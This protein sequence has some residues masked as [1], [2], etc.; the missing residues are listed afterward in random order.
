MSGF[1]PSRPAEFL[2]SVAVALLLG[3]PPLGAQ[4][5]PIQADPQG[6]VER[7]SRTRDRMILNGRWR[8]QP[9]TREA[10]K[11]P[12]AD[13]GLLSVPGT[14]QRTGWMHGMTGLP[15]PEKR[16]SGAAWQDLGPNLGR[17]WYERE[18]TI[19][20]EW[21]GRRIR[22]DFRRVSTDATVWIDRT[23]CGR[24]EWPY[25]VVDITKAARPGQKALLRVLVVATPDPGESVVWMGTAPGQNFSVKS[26]LSRS[27]LIGDV[28]LES[29]PQ[30]AV[31]SDV[32][33]Q[34]SVARKELAIDVELEGFR[35]AAGL[36]FE[37]RLLDESGT[38]EQRFTA[39]A[40]PAGTGPTRTARL[41]FP[42][43]NPRLWDLGRPNLYTLELAARGPGIDDTYALRFGFREFRVEGRKFLLNGREI[44]L[45]PTLQEEPGTP[46]EID[47]VIDGMRAAGFNISQMWPTDHDKRG[48]AF[49]HRELWAER[50]DAKGWLTMGSLLSMAPY[51][52]DTRYRFIWNAERRE[53]YRRRMEADL[54]RYRNHPSIVMWGTTGNFFN[55]SADQDPRYLG[56]RG[57]VPSDATDPKV[58]AGREALDLIRKADPTR[59]VFT[60]AGNRMGDVF[61]IN[62]YLN[63]IP[64]QEREE[65]PSEWARDGEMPVL[66]IEFGNPLFCDFLRGR[67]A[68]QNN[69]LSEPLLTEHAA[70]FLGPEAY[71]IETPEYRA[72]IRSRY[73]GAEKWQNW[74]S[75]AILMGAPAMDKVSALLARNTWRAWRTWGWSGGMIPWDMH[76]HHFRSTPPAPQPAPPFQP[77]QRGPSPS[78]LQTRLLHYLKPEGGWQLNEAGRA[79]LAA[80]GP[81]LAWIAGPEPHFT[82]KDHNYRPGTRFE[83]QAIL[84]NDE[85]DPQTFTLSWALT[86]GDAVL[87]E[88][89]EQGEL[90]SAE[91]RRIP[92][93]ADLPTRIAAAK[94]DALLTLDA[95]IGGDRHHDR[96]VF[97]IHA[98]EPGRAKTQRLRT[99]DPLGKTKPLLAHLNLRPVDW[100]GQPHP[101]LLIVG[102]EA[103]SS[104]TPLPG[105]PSP[106]RPLRALEDYVLAGGRVLVMTQS[107]AW[108]RDSVGF[109]TLT[110]PARAVFPVDP[111]HPLVAGL[112]AD[113]LRDWSGNAT[114]LEP[115]PKYD[116]ASYPLH[117]W[118]WG[119][120]GVVASVPIEKPHRSG[121]RPL[122]EC[123]FDLAYSPL[124]ELD[125]GKGRITLCTLDLEDCHAAD[126]VA[127]QLARR[128]I[129]HAASAPLQPRA[130]RV[131]LL[132][133]AGDPTLTPIPGVRGERAAKLAP[134]GGLAIIGPDAALPA[135]DLEAYLAAGGR[136]FFLAA[137]SP[138]G[139]PI[140]ALRET[141]DYAGSTEPPDWPETAGIGISDLHV[142]SSHPAWLLEPGDGLD[143]AAGGL[144]GR[145]ARGRGTLFFCQ[146]DPGALPADAQPWLRF[147]RWRQTRLVTQLLANHGASFDADARFFQPRPER[148]DLTGIWEYL[149]TR[150]L[151]ASPDPATRTADPGISEAA[152]ALIAAN[153]T[154]DA[155]P[156]RVSGRDQLPEFDKADGEAVLW[157]TFDLP[158]DAAQA[159]L[160]L[161]LGALDDFDQVFLN[162][163]LVGETGAATPT[164]W[165]VRRSYRIPPG[166]A[167]AGS[168]RIAIR[169]FD[170]Y[171]GGGFLPADRPEHLRILRESRGLP[172]F[173]HPDYRADRETGDDPERYYR[174]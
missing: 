53:T 19:P 32:F 148:I 129:V 65:M 146:A 64:S 5:A 85:R 150:P 24:V 49:Q 37:A 167:V 75:N 31:I 13:W 92:I 4:P 18:I 104:G 151:P 163:K 17:A 39:Q 166:I 1:P 63:L 127:D 79:L 107:P 126:P 140:S 45:R 136:A 168:N 8:F 6:P 157:T 170:A 34:P 155:K 174:W 128:L 29:L 50:A 112:D 16:G 172:G 61:T 42:W 165:S 80:N 72:A 124:L 3:T 9:A 161:E 46:A 105:T 120:R 141:K 143:I 90:A 47:G 62:H 122:L 134:D 131:Q 159:A 171:G 89:T 96:F 77:G 101:D 56:R 97:R 86:A 55:Q 102:R 20:A 160:T 108:L 33:V 109:R 133:N 27:G 51:I 113:D 68:F 106:E 115:R 52:V 25:G 152:R 114:L 99:W 14:W 82:A 54:R 130:E 119:N 144:L 83:K 48:N 7:V 2:R 142:R 22:L 78:T 38:E 43:E 44:R 28:V 91:T 100:D 153:P 169:L 118:R 36:E 73:A 110:F 87:A 98:P 94:T 69:T 11:A 15:E 84:I 158:S 60:H 139:L 35:A 71:H 41:V 103:L 59:P 81:T 162:G 154:G 117:G 132:G 76:Y 149:I 138:D 30:G 57:F 74:Q 156:S 93:A 23:E 173:Y 164:P 12:T 67:N 26:T 137:N 125:Y 121:W 145:T 40:A 95:T 116:V 58:A 135:A 70:A 111:G 147:T 88:G 10:A 66:S 123:G 21:A